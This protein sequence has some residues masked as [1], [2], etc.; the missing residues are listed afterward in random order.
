MRHATPL[1]LGMA[2]FVFTITPPMSML[3]SLMGL[4]GIHLPP[5]AAGPLMAAVHSG[6]ISPMMHKL[7]ATLMGM[8]GPAAA[9]SRKG[10]PVSGKATNSTPASPMSMDSPTAG[11]P[12]VN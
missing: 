8:H 4:A 3:P 5:S 9:R 6:H 1:N 12:G 10:M 11:A 2:A 7:G